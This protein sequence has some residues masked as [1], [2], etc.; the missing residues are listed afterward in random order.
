MSASGVFQLQLTVMSGL[1]QL[2][3]NQNSATRCR[4]PPPAACA[5]D[6]T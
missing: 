3:Q 2:L 6:L 1:S 5:H 4:F